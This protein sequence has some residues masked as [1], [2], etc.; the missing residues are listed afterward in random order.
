MR[1][2][3]TQRLTAASTATALTLGML[4]ALAAGPAA[5]A[6]GPVEAGIV[7][8]KVDGMPTDFIN[9]VDVSSALALEDSGVIFRDDQG[10]PADLFEVL[11]DHDVTD[12]RVRVWNDPFDADGNGYGGGDVDVDRAVEIGE[13]ATAAGLGLLVDFHY[14]DFWADPAKQQSP[15][16]WT[17]LTVD[18]KATE[19]REYT[20]AAL[21][22]FEAAGVDV[23]MVQV[24]NETNNGVAGVTGWPGMA[25]I[26]SAGSAAVRE[27]YPDALVAVH[28]T[29]PESAGRYAGYAAELDARGVDY[30]VFA[31]SYYP[32]W[33]GS[34]A[35]L[36]SVLRQVADT[37]DKK[38]MVA[39][40]SWA[41]TLEDADGHSNVIDL[42]SEATQYPISV[43]GQA[44][45]VRDVIEAVVDV[46]D[47]GIG[48]FYWEPAWLPVGPPDQLAQNSVLWE[49]DG[50][51]W[52][53]SFAG[54]Y[55]PEDAGE[56]YGGS[57]WDNQALFAADGTPL[58]S[59]RVFSYARTGAVAPLA[60][61]DVEDPTVTLTDGDAIALP[62]TVTVTY[63]DRSTAEEAVT[64][65]D[66]AEWI[67][68]PG[69]YR[70]T[71]ETTS[72]ER[73]TAT[74]VIRPVNALRN[75]G[76]EDADLS[77][78]SRTGSALTLRAT[79]DPR[80]GSRSAH[81][82]SGSAYTFQLTQTVTGL[83][84]G[85]YTASGSLQGD[86][87]GA[88]GSV[89]IAVSAGSSNASAPFALDGWRNWSAPATDPITVAAGGSATVTVT[90]TLP[91]GAWGSLDDLVLTR[92]SEVVDTA[93][94]KALVARAEGIDRKV[95]TAASFAPLDD[96]VRVAGLVLA[97]SAPTADRVDR[98][99]TLL[100]TALE[101]LV[102][103]GPEPA[104]VVVPVAVTVEE[105]AGV[106][107]P[108]RASVRT[109]NGAVVEREATW[110]D[111]ASW[112]S[113]P[114]TYTV[115]GRVGGIATTAKVTVTAATW[116]RNGGFESSDVSMWDVRG[117]GATI[118][119]SSDAAA[120]SRAVAFWSGSPYT[121][122]VTQRIT[123][124]TPGTYAV[125]AVGQGD[126]EG[127]G[128]VRVTAA[129]AS[130]A[131]SAPIALEGW[132]QFRTGT[133]PVVTVGADG[134]LTVG[135]SADLPAEAWGT[136]DSIRVV[137][138]GEKTDTAALR[139]DVTALAALDGAAYTTW[140]FAR[141]SA[142]L[143]KARIVLGADWP[144]AAQ[145][146]AARTLVAD[147]KAALVRTGA[148]AAVAA[149][150][151]GVLSN[152]N[153]WDTGLKDGAYTVTV[154]LWWGE[155]ASSVRLY[156]NGRLVGVVPVDYR[157]QRAQSV[158]VPVSG[159]K[160][161]TYRYTAV[162]VNTK[163]ET[164]TA[165]MDVVVDAAKPGVPVLSHDN[166]D[167]DGTYT[168]TANLWWG[169]NAT[170]YRV[171]QDGAVVA[172]G[173]L[174]AQT[175]KAQKVTYRASGMPRGG[176]VYVVEFVNGAGVTAGKP[177]T[178][179]VLR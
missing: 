138:A 105:G 11:A 168:V 140:S 40:T 46:G 100:L 178:V 106:A 20:A 72:G 115:S 156:E 176:H 76:F 42:A 147:A 52:A 26:F 149:P 37:Y 67:G 132:Q 134:V 148:D 145:V 170:S 93:D 5:A 36:T 55:D 13:R 179:T 97:S 135:V 117:T 110:S 45:A 49:R 15:K 154:N 73:T 160:D 65:S 43:Q 124:V 39:E 77:M 119:A 169:T 80:S 33:H 18:E 104:P 126:G 128:S 70:V 95:A 133:T 81:F 30:D 22:Q 96:A 94:L 155:N 141:V 25:K 157:G 175:P 107:L 1:A 7:V 48:V 121:F 63:N 34:T 6:D 162:L 47:A 2:S 74:V 112:I 78:W 102:L 32:Y 118:G 101:G 137:R 114:G 123:G 66:D 23:R 61:V 108:A 151:T 136:V 75:P 29:N 171:R 174:V 51:G 161:G 158:T 59:L 64:W 98:A 58:E 86:G 173:A 69:T 177:V 62:A 21:E 129:T 8:D 83:P 90:A 139:A 152:D 92:A 144:T 79:D 150:G 113:G 159:R 50:S 9:G 14:S 127:S 4:G 146:A 54:E 143:E 31:S 89:R 130:G 167:G 71:G 116:V 99:E 109:W 28:F 87:E 56:Y 111:A 53:S 172:E 88:D 17:S 24:G 44:T 27:V 91:A 41:H 38:V 122:A 16:A 85:R 164:T 68:G 166:H 131:Q 125:S 142:A 120:G 84:A 153:G 3:R 163:G 103:S 19:T 60:V 35:N 12:V 10:R 165:A 82:Y 57:A